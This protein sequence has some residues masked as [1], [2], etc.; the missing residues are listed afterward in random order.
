M[1]LLWGWYIKKP[2]NE[3]DSAYLH[4]WL[5]KH[6]SLDMLSKKELQDLVERALDSCG[7]HERIQTHTELCQ[8]ILSGLSSCAGFRI[9]G[10]DGRTLN[11]LLL[12]ACHAHRWHIPELQSLSFK[13]LEMCTPEQLENMGKGISSLLTSYILSPVPNGDSQIIKGSISKI[14]DTLL[15]CSRIEA[16]SAIAFAS[17]AVLKAIGS[18]ISTS[19]FLKGNPSSWW[20]VLVHH[21]SFRILKN[22]SEWLRFERELARQEIDVLC[23]YLRHLSD[24]EKCVFL[25]RHWFNPDAQDGDTLLDGSPS[26]F[27]KQLNDV[28]VSCKHTTSPFVCMF[29]AIGPRIHSDG[30]ALPRVFSL[31]HRLEMHD[32]S[33]SLFRYFR[34]SGTSVNLTTLA[35]KIINYTS[36]DPRV[37]CTLFKLTPSLPLESCPVVAEI[38][39]R[40]PAVH[41]GIPLGFRD[42]R[43]GSLG[44]PDVYPRTKQEIRHAQIQ[45]LNRMATAYAHASHLYPRVAFR[46]V[47]QCYLLHRK[48]ARCSLSVEIS[49]ALTIAGAVRPLQESEWVST[50]KLR[51]ILAI[52]RETEGDEVA[53]RV[54]ELVYAWR[55]KIHR[56]EARMALEMRLQQ[57]LGLLPLEA[58]E[59]E[60]MA[61]SETRTTVNPRD[62]LGRLPGEMRADKFLRVRG[63]RDLAF[64][65]ACQAAAMRENGV[66]EGDLMQVIRGLDEN[67]KEEVPAIPLNRIFSRW[68]D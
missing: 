28:R 34:Q 14:L 26:I 35:S 65:R 66:A 29:Q 44:I 30:I 8:T 38:M 43:Q 56:E 18:T 15:V 32:T 11:R 67:S 9:P 7:C 42:A 20:S 41:P 40:D 31:L 10:L 3:R 21:E 13:I 22:G 39:I 57:R 61:E 16:G 55:G 33:L 2:R 54:D 1:Q 46:Q 49:A 53:S 50:M 12:A 59:V 4:S 36:P 60:P 48:H 6:I 47:Y 17:R 62:R 64:A 51:W 24:D 45:L 27:I 19:S 68:V 37:A 5:R 58:E 63:A 52:V 25:V 23:L